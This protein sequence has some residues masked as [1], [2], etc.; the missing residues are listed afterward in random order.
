KLQQRLLKTFYTARTIIEEQGVN[1]LFLAVGML[2]WYES[3]SSA[4]LRRYYD[5]A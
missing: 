3:E 5:R 4:E 2:Q 1:T